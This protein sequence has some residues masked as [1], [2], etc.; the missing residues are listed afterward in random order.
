MESIIIEYMDPKSQ[1]SKPNIKKMRTRIL[2]PYEYKKLR[3]MPNSTYRSFFDAALLTGMR[4]VELRLFLGHPDWFDGEFIHIPGIAIKKQKA[5]VKQMWVHLSIKRRMV[6]ENL[7][8]N[9]NPG[10]IPTEQ[11]IIK[12]LKA[13]SAKS[14][15]GEQGNNMKMFR[16]SY[17]FWLIS[18]YP[19]KKE[20]ILCLRAMIP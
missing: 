5:T 15:I 20:E 10:I 9:V 16:K 7:H 18:C 12:Y 1:I 3:S 6:M 2:R 8:R 13:A 19:E 14:E 11:G 4:V 17:E